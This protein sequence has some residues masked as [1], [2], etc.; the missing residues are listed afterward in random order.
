LKPI[1]A[2]QPLIV[3]SINDHLG[4]EYGRFAIRY[5]LLCIPALSMLGALFF[6]WAGRYVREDIRKSAAG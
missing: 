4:Q 1:A 5:S 2:M 6:I 3:D